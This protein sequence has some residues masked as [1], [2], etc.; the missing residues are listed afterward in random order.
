[1]ASVNLIADG[2]MH[3]DGLVMPPAGSAT[4]YNTAGEPF[5]IVGPSSRTSPPHC[6]RLARPRNA[7]LDDGLGQCAGGVTAA[8]SAER[9]E[10]WPMRLPAYTANV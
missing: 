5:R 6:V 3:H 2:W 10:R 1:M 7:T 8:M 9:D 4:Y